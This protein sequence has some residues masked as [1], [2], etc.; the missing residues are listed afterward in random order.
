M[1]EQ[2]VPGA[3]PPS[4]SAGDEAICTILAQAPVTE[5]HISHIKSY[6]VVT[7]GILTTL[8]PLY[9]HNHGVYNVG[10][11][12]WCIFSI[13]NRP[14]LSELHHLIIPGQ[15]EVKVIQ[16]VSTRWKKLAL[17]LGFELS[18]VESIGS[19]YSDSEEDCELMLRK[20][21]MRQ[22]GTVSWEVL[23]TA[24]ENIG[25]YSIADDLE[26]GNYIWIWICFWFH[27]PPAHS[28]PCLAWVDYRID[29]T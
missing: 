15:K 10:C 19:R 24:L 23:M 29:S 18:V 2:C 27:G 3:L 4:A 7:A 13:G 25:L 28:T 14:S 9:I 26:K 16:E 22:D 20:W 21:L 17:E 12:N 11:V 6:M 8:W 1:R 5:I